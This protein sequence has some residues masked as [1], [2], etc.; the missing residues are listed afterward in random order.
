MTATQPD[1]FSPPRPAASAAEVTALIAWLAAHPGWHPAAKIAAALSLTDRKVRALAERSN[2]LIVSGPG[3]PGYCHSSH[4]SAEE[5][6]HAAETL[7][8]QARRMMARAISIKKQAIATI[9]TNP[10]HTTP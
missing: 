8:S 6:S 1:L 5:I 10:R 9:T 7:V 4:C 2:G 3:T